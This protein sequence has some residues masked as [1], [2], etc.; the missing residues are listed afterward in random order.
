VSE[1]W[2]LINK[3]NAIF[4]TPKDQRNNSNKGQKSPVWQT[5]YHLPFGRDII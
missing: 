4:G 2:H 5:N 3:A 1:N